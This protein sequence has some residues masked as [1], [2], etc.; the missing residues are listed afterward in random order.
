[1]RI[2]SVLKSYETIKDCLSIYFKKPFSNP[3]YVADAEKLIR[4]EYEHR[5]KKVIVRYKRRVEK[6]M[7]LENVQETL[8]RRIEFGR[9]NLLG[10]E[11]YHILDDGHLLGEF[12]TT[13]LLLKWCML[14]SNEQYQV[15]EGTKVP[16][17]WAM[18]TIFALYGN[19]N[20]R[21]IKMA[22]DVFRS[23]KFLATEVG[24]NLMDN[25]EDEIIEDIE[26]VARLKPH[27]VYDELLKSAD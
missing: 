10:F 3:D 11:Y 25:L 12:K 26:R 5:L 18:A 21:D 16:I 22:P 2:I 19:T 24:L 27:K 1:M 17:T 23:F 13:L 9:E 20:C 4:E 7:E 8:K 14:P 15:I 6:Y